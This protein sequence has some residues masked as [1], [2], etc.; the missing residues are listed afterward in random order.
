MRNIFALISVVVLMAMTLGCSSEA[1][2]KDEKKLRDDFAQKEFDINK[3]PAD[4]RAMIQGMIDA[5]KSGNA[6]APSRK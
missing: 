2:A 4:K 3:V 5:Q 1:T 6:T